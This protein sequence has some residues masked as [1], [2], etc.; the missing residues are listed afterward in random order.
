[1]AGADRIQDGMRRSFGKPTD[2]A[3]RVKEG[4]ELVT[5]RAYAKDYFVALDALKRASDRFPTTCKYKVG[6]GQELVDEFLKKRQ[7]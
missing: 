6:K 7:Q 2:R 1:V 4:Q 3:A 5:V